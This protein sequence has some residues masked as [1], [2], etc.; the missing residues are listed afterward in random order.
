[1]REGESGDVRGGIR[2]EE[3]HF[4]QISACSL[5]FEI[6]CRSTLKKEIFW[7]MP[8]L[9]SIK[10]QTFLYLAACNYLQPN[11]R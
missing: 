10:L 7:V 8:N 2:D 5:H 4:M 3:R 6:L 1:M 9:M 11:Q